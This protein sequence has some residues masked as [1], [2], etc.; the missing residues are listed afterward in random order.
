MTAPSFPFSRVGLVGFGL[1]GGSL[2][3]DLKGLRDAPEVLALSA[4]PEEVELG[5]RAGLV[6]R[7]PETPEALC[8]RADLVVYATPLEATLRLLEEHQPHWGKETVVTDVVSLKAPLARAMDELGASRRYVGSH[9]M[10][11][12]E[13]SGFV[14]SRAGLFHGARVWLTS[15]GAS[16]PVQEKVA[17]F[18]SALGAV[19]S[20]TRPPAHDRLMV[21][22]SHLPQLLANALALALEEEGIPLDDLGTGGRDMT[23]LAGSAP[24]M[25]RDLFRHAP[26]DLTRALA[27]LEGQL[28]RLRGLL[29]EENVGAVAEVMEETRAWWRGPGAG[30]RERTGQEEPGTDGPQTPEETEEEWS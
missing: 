13:G 2:A 10:A 21:W 17:G 27:S 18:W 6:D 28:G 16:K 29:E 5:R 15:T 8:Q 30:D 9:P 7:L 14:S 11:G 24:G 23:R 26:E 12:G 22:V 4:D 25:W 3:R 19:P 1:M 20:W